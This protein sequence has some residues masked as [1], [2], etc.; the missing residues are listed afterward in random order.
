MSRRPLVLWDIDGTLLST[1]GV[2]RSALSAAFEALHG[3]PDAFEGL[4][5]AGR[6]DSGICADAYRRAALT[7]SDA[8]HGA[9]QE[10]YLEQLEA[11]LAARRPT[12][13][14]G[15]HDALSAS[16]RLG[17]SGL[18][19]GN[20]AAGAQRKLSAVDLWGRFAVGAFGDDSPDRDELVPV[21]RERARR[22]GW[23]GGPVVV[24]G[25]TVHDVSCARAG[26]AIAVAMLTGWGSR[27]AL[28]AAGPDLLLED[29]ERGLDALLEVLQG[30]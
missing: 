12:L 9:L 17:L 23:E 7:P 5:F 6:T 2:G 16:E 1:G 3:V 15:V 30:A 27:E 29:L 28:T 14:P 10:R 26:G 21:A 18:L 19:T 25:D 22:L 8:E 11:R 13:A 24:I 4:S 20:W